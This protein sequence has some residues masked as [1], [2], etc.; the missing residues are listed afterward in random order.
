VAR[1]ALDHVDPAFGPK[2]R[3]TPKTEINRRVGEAADLLGWQRLGKKVIRGI[4]P[5]D[6]EDSAFVDLHFF[7]PDTG[8]SV[9]HEPEGLR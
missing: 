2:L 8:E 7:D 5:S 1:I 4:R 3:H 6:F 9:G